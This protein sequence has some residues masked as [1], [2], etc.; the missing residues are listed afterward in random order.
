MFIKKFI[1][2]YKAISP[3][4]IALYI[5]LYFRPYIAAYI[6]DAYLLTLF[7]GTFYIT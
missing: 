1:R 7:L 2:K 4:S 5:V 3:I 6:V